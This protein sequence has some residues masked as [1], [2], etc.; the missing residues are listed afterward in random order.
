M[1]L[2]ALIGLSRA[3]D[4]VLTGRPVSAKEAL[5]IGLANRLVA[6]GTGRHSP[7]KAGKDSSTGKHSPT[8]EDMG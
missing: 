8:S 3:L 1:R 5:D 4:L 7:P 6:T 2:P